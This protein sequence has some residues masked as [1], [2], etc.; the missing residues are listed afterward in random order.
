[1][2]C[3]SVRKQETGTGPDWAQDF[4]SEKSIILFTRRWQPATPRTAVM[5]GSSMGLCVHCCLASAVRCQCNANHSK[6]YSCAAA[7]SLVFDL[8]ISIIK[9]RGKGI[10]PSF[11]PS[12]L[13]CYVVNGIAP[14]SRPSLYQ[15]NDKLSFQPLPV[16]ARLKFHLEHASRHYSI[17]RQ[18]Q[19]QPSQ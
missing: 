3:L 15:R 5:L 2:D 1:L 18:R 19:R 8:S 6:L 9:C 7:L 16:T 13:L 11:P 10:L 17:Q 12:A 14:F 4:C